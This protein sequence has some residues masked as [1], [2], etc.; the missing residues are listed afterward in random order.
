MQGFTKRIQL[1]D[2]D[3]ENWIG[4]EVEI[5]TQQYDEY[6][7]TFKEGIQ[8]LILKLKLT[9]VLKGQANEKVCEIMIWKISV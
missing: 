6:A 2:A 3:N 8:Y 5:D 9:L 7:K 4:F 1:R